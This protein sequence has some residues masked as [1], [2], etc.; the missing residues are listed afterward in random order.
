MGGR[1]IQDIRALGAR[2]WGNV[3]MD[4]ENWLKLLKKYRV[5]TGLSSQ[6]WRSWIVYGEDKN[7]L[8]LSSLWL[9]T[10]FGMVTRFV[11]HFTT[12]LGTIN[13]YGAIANLNNLQIT[14]ANTKSSPACCAFT[15]RSLATAS[16]SGDSSTSRSH[17]IP[18]WPPSHDWTWSK[19]K[20]K[21]L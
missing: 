3:V 14:A 10:G 21:L 20:S 13:N 12:R 5:H 8:R 16:S 4:T 6:W 1:L 17:A 2:I 19:S 11:D 15:S 9:S 7:S 18:G